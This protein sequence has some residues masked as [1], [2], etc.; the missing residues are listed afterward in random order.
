MDPNTGYLQVHGTTV[1]ANTVPG[2]Y[3]PEHCDKGVPLRQK[4][5]HRRI[6]PLNVFILSFEDL[7]EQLSRPSFRIRH[8]LWQ[9][10]PERSP[11][12]LISDD[13]TMHS[14]FQAQ[15]TEPGKL[16]EVVAVSYV[17]E[18]TPPPDPQDPIGAVQGYIPLAQGPYPDFTSLNQLAAMART[19]P[20][21]ANAAPVVGPDFAFDNNP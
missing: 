12:S 13:R 21:A 20:S 16:M 8:L 4:A 15:L 9:P 1:G 14:W 7:I 11:W 5:R 2:Y 17:R 18:N 3:L 10:I 6:Q 19:R